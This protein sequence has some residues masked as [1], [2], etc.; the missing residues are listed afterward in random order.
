MALHPQPPDSDCETQPA[1]MTVE[2]LAEELKYCSLQIKPY[3]N[4]YVIQIGCVERVVE[5]SA[6]DL[7]EMLQVLYT[8]R[9][10]FLEDYGK[11]FG[12]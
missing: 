12:L 9:G 3:P 7:G 11:R 8:N 5:G 4:G 1:A 6:W 10:K 2:R